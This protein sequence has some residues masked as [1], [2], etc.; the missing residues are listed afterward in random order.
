MLREDLMK[1]DLLSEIVLLGS[2]VAIVVV[3]LLICSGS[4]YA[5]GRAGMTRV[6]GIARRPAAMPSRPEVQRVLLS[7]SPFMKPNEIEASTH[8]LN[9]RS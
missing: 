8:S 3:L 6:W 4:S 5:T 7:P 1:P 9:V 2:A